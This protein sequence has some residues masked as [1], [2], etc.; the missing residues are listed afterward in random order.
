MTEN[1]TN[2]INPFLS[3]TESLQVASLTFKLSRLSEECNNLNIRG[4]SNLKEL[5]PLLKVKDD[6]QSIIDMIELLEDR[7]YFINEEC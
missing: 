7:K 1:T 4:I 5:K 6:L 2:N 3:V